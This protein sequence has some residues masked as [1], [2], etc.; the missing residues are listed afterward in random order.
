MVKTPSTIHTCGISTTEE[1]L[2]V[3]GFEIFTAVHKQK[4]NWMPGI[5]RMIKENE[6]ENCYID[7]QIPDANTFSLSC[8]VLV[9]PPQKWYS[10]IR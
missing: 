1:D 4:E 6:T 9:I 8:L 2:L 7:I 10:R 5:C 3:T